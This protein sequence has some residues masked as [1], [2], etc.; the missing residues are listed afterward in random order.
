[1]VRPT[2][3]AAP[4]TAVLDRL[5]PECPPPSDP[6]MISEAVPRR[7]EVAAEALVAAKDFWRNFL[8]YFGLRNYIFVRLS[9][10]CVLKYFLDC[11]PFLRTDVYFVV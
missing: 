11:V 3:L 1:M 10:S 2:V 7:N 4:K 8:D 5:A 9:V 6:S